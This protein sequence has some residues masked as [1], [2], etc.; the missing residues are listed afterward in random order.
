MTDV[1]TS[2][3][4]GTYRV[5]ARDGRIIAVKPFELDPDPSPIGQ[6]LIGALTH[7]CRVTRPMVRK[8]WLEKGPA[9]TGAGRGSEP[10]VALSW[11]EATE[12]AARELQRVKRE[13]GNEAIFGGS[14]GWASAGRFHHAQSQLKR[15]LNLHGGFTASVNSYS[16]GAGA[17][18]VPH[19]VGHEY[20]DAVGCAMSWDQIAEHSKLVVMLGG[21]SGKNSQTEA[22]GVGRHRL[23]TWLRRARDNGVAFV[24]LSPVRSDAEAMLGAQWIPMR[25]NTDVP[26][27]LGMAH[28]LVA[29]GL[30]D[31]AFL[32]RY[33]VGYP[34]FERYLLGLDDGVAKTAEWAA[35]I[36]GVDAET[37]RGLARRMAGTRTMIGASWSLQRADHG[38]QPYWM[39][40]TLAA[41][42]GQVGLPGGGFSFGHGSMA[43][44]GMPGE[45]FTGPAVP[46]G[47]NHVR[48]F[49]PVAR[50]A[51]LLERPGGTLDYDGKTLRL[52]DIQLIY[53]AGGNPF[54]HHQDI[55][56]LRRAWA[57]PDTVIVHEQVWT[58]L[59]KHADIVLPAT[60]GLERNDLGAN[61]RDSDLFA[62]KQVVPPFGE[63]RNDHE[64]FADIAEHLGF[65]EAF[66]EG[67]SERQWLAH[68][69][70]GLRRRHQW[71][72]D[73]DEFWERGHF[74][75]PESSGK[76]LFAGFRADPETYKLSTP[77]GRIELFSERVA[78]FGYADCPGHAVWLE[79]VEWLGSPEARRHK[80]HLLSNQPV[81]RLHSQLDFGS[82]SLSRKIAGREPIYIH[83]KDAAAR[84]IASGD[85]VRVFNDR[86]QCL[87]G[88]VVTEGVLQGVVQMSTGAWY[89][90]VDP[91]VPG[92]LDANGN[93][94]VLT[95][96]KGTSSLAQGANA[97]S[98]LVEI[99]LWR[100][101]L[102]PVRAYDAPRFG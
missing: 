76:V 84:G 97:N 16:Y 57:K 12:L 81:G 58:G 79:P 83:E 33:T 92:S 20:A 62:S 50:I 70:G 25:P 24:N 43:S 47:Q 40:V 1:F 4:W 64:I 52:P 94:N 5:E 65:R 28:T 75:I 99:E 30:C 68:L 27:L 15:F 86:G 80:L 66:T 71:L 77:S 49:I 10:F 2:T 26:L 11:T 69:Y 95:L 29:E 46:Q 72:P 90:P 101:D 51:E 7:P 31:R 42:L 21:I 41:M 13:H 39:V 61:T 17:V 14:Y 48:T 91:A 9:G 44:V 54:H 88:A 59:A 96:D 73:F 45:R 8:G 102:P 63:A 36:S 56:R 60:F 93:V 89:D 98:C 32:D 6:S 100:N 53:W 67:R 34:R 22:G 19:L 87:A 38:E 37:I 3:H 85:V 35:A 18:V 23:S 55:N 82:N 74:E 78:G